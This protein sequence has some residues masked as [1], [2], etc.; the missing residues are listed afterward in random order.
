MFTCDICAK[1][2]SRRYNM[3]RHKRQVH[4]NDFQSESDT[5][6]TSKN[7]SYSDD[8]DGTI[9]INGSESDTLSISEDMNTSSDDTGG[10]K[11]NDYSG[12]EDTMDSSS[13]TEEHEDPWM[14]II[15]VTFSKW[16]PEYK[17]K[18]QSYM[19]TD[20][21]TVDIA[22][23]RA[24]RDMKGRYRKTIATVFTDTIQWFNAI[25]KDPVYR[26]IK[27]TASD[28][29]LVDDYASEEA[30]KYATS[31]RKYLFE[32]ILNRYEPPETKSPLSITQS[33]GGIL[34]QKDTESETETERIKRWVEEQEER[35][36]NAP[37]IQI[38][39]SRY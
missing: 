23:K 11:S 32:N 22:R 25:R 38:I 29:M 3:L 26:S 21:V 39:G 16:Q 33:G 12:D 13:E 2:F 19:E 8:E 30:W 6:S 35:R 14:G 37:E 7:T 31:K 1:T 27:K 36:K 5:L 34:Q 4:A 28:L 20:G 15:D 9:S 24:F 18:V 10:N 17:E